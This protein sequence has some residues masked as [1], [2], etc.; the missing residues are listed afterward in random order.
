MSCLEQ[1]VAEFGRELGSRSEEGL[2]GRNAGWAAAAGF[3]II[4]TQQNRPLD[5]TSGGHDAGG[6][7][8]FILIVQCSELCSSLFDTGKRPVPLSILVIC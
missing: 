1:V 7:L 8:T 4:P 2:P 6:T 3:P 5:C